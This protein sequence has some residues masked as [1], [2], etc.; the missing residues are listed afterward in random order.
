MSI[1]HLN[2]IRK[3][4][5]QEFCPH[6]DMSDYAGRPEAAINAARLSRALAAFALTEFAQVT[7]AEAAA[8]VV[9]GYGDHGIDAIGVARQNGVVV[10]VQSKWDDDGKGSPALGDVE[11][12]IRGFNDLLV[13][14]F[15]R[16]NEKIQAKREELTEALDNTSVRFE[17]VLVH[18][19]QQPLSND[20]QD[21]VD[22]LLR[23]INDVSEIVTF[24]YLAQSGLH[25]MVKQG[26]AGT[27]PDLSVTLHDWGSTEEPYLAFYG[28]VDATDV[29]EW[30]EEHQA[31]LFDRN[32]RK[33]IHDSSVN[34]AIATTLLNEPSN[35]WYFNN[36]LTVLC[37]RIQKAPVGGASRRS[38]KFA[39]Q[40]ATVVNGAQTVGSIGLAAETDPSK[41]SDARVH[42][43]FISLENCPADFATDVTRATNTQNRVERRDFVALDPEQE[44]LR[45]D[46]L[47][48]QGKTYAIKTGEPD[49]VR[50]QGCTVVDATIA[51][52]CAHSPELA[53][54]A[55]R[56]IGRLWEDVGKIPY[57]HLFNGALTATR[58][59]RAVQ[60]LRE[61]DDTLR[62]EQK[63]LEGRDRSIAVHG[64]RLIAHAV[65]AAL[66]PPE[67]PKDAEEDIDI[68][69]ADLTR[70]AVTAMQQIIERDFPGNYLASLFKNASR[71]REVIESLPDL[72]GAA[73]S[74]APA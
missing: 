2:H 1:V 24:H 70:R 36:G 73:E 42:V 72:S 15:D 50:G 51:L 38:G 14:R 71:C 59:W 20:A 11:K 49:P 64:N 13:P 57:K 18:T 9:D 48:E 27:S 60:I 30:W 26:V 7:P 12:F 34:A 6:I 37:N 43:R 68:D 23:D 52:A 31:T 10:V 47:L 61:V 35:F 40:G 19:G 39:F 4:L 55:K 25:S 46:L 66:L 56:E 3:K 69:I 33:F 44:R 54:Q 17:L 29:A 62:D 67:P 21:V 22:D 74:V 41:V 8:D 65:F 16:F 28:Q 45:T 5:E 63:K 58:L 53:V 32:L